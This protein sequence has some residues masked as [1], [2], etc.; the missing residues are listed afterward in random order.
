LNFWA[1]YK[2]LSRVTQFSF[3][4][5]KSHTFFYY[6]VFVLQVFMQ[7][8]VSIRVLVVLGFLC[9]WVSNFLIQKFRFDNA[10]TRFIFVF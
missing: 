3:L 4:N 8:Y 7:V 10:I 2:S 5:L 9:G 6:V 1:G